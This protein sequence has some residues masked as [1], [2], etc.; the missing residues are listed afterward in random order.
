MS[1]NSQSPSIAVPGVRTDA[2]LEIL[3]PFG[4]FSRYDLTNNW[5]ILGHQ[6]FFAGK[7]LSES[8]EHF[9]PQRLTSSCMRVK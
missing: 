7:V 2:G 4:A 5:S 1:A 9:N 3:E 8:E 6:G